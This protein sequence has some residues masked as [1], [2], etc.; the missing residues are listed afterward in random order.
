MRDVGALRLVAAAAMLGVLGSWLLGVWLHVRLGRRARTAGARRIVR[1]VIAAPMQLISSRLVQELSSNPY[2]AAAI[3][4]RLES[5]LTAVVT[6][7]TRSMKAAPPAARVGCR[8]D[9]LGAQCR[10]RIRVDFTPLLEQHGAISQRWVFLFWPIW[11]FFAIAGG[12]IQVS[13]VD[14]PS[15]WQALSLAL[16]AMPLVGEIA[17]VG[18]AGRACRRLGDAIIGTAD[19]LRSSLLM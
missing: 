4:G 18:R 16:G 8:L 3:T 19:D 10:L 9:D 6:P 13:L 11:G 7:I 15:P 14:S 5:V 2:F 12:L 1:F 17:I